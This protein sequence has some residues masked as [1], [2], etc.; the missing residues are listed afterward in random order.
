MSFWS[1]ADLWSAF[2]VAGT[3]IENFWIPA[4]L[5]RTALTLAC[6]ID[7]DLRLRTVGFTCTDTPTFLITVHLTHGTLEVNN[8][9][10]TGT[11]LV[12]KRK[13]RKTANVLGTRTCTC[14][15]VEDFWLVT[16]SI[17]RTLT[18]TSLGTEGM[19]VGALAV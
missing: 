3:L 5:L 8:R 18:L 1:V 16:L 11:C 6:V 9:T 17:V 12:V 13:R 10:V 14:V 7:E 15:S 2:T 4:D 19:T